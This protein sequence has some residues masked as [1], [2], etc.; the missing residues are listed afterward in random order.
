MPQVGQNAGE[1]ERKQLSQALV[2]SINPT[3]QRYQWLSQHF[4]H[5][6]AILLLELFSTAVFGHTQR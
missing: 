6:P 4:Q 5:D 2:G 3:F 1:G